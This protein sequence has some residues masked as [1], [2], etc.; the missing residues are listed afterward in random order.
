MI[1]NTEVTTAITAVRRKPTER[2]I[3]PLNVEYVRVS[4]VASA[5]DI[6]RTSV[7]ALIARGDLRAIKVGS[8][9]RVSLSSLNQLVETGGVKQL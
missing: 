8:R 3:S 6:S 2:H 5:L 9:M 4:R 1:G 7:Y